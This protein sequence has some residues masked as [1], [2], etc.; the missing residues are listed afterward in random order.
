[1]PFMVWLCHARH[2]ASDALHNSRITTQLRGPPQMRTLNSY[3]T[4]LAASLVAFSAC[5][6][7][8]LLASDHPSEGRASELALPS[9]NI[10]FKASTTHRPT[11]QL[12]PLDHRPHFTGPPNPRYLVCKT[13]PLLLQQRVNTIHNDPAKLLMPADTATC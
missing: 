2:Y 1:M 10:T 7:C 11:M 6:Q 3:Q 5:G 12:T 8:L 9:L 4:Y 13:K